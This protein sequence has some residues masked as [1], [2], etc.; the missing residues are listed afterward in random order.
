MT[1]LIDLEGG[2]SALVA[3]LS[4]LSVRLSGCAALSWGRA[5]DQGFPRGASSFVLPAGLPAWPAKWCALGTVSQPVM[6][7]TSGE[8]WGPCPQ[9]LFFFP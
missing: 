4:G 1:S 5:G 3:T 8:C 9:G 7:P 2:A 6:P